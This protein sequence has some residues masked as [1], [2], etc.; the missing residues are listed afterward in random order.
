[1]SCGIFFAL[2]FL[3]FKSYLPLSGDN[4]PDSR[5]NAANIQSSGINPIIFES[6]LVRPSD[7]LRKPACSFISSKGDAEEHVVVEE[8]SKFIPGSWK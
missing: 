3:W 4:S 7:E 6:E 2:F 1:M 5:C 8:D